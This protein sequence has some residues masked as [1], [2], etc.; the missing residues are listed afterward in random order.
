MILHELMSKILE[1]VKNC[2]TDSDNYLEVLQYVKDIYNC[3]ISSKLDVSEIK[4]IKLIDKDYA[5]IELNEDILIGVLMIEQGNWVITDYYDEINIEDLRTVY[6]RLTS[7]EF[8]DVILE[9]MT[10]YSKHPEC[11]NNLT[12][13]FTQEEITKG[14][15]EFKTREQ[16]PTMFGFI[17]QGLESYKFYQKEL[18][19]G[20]GMIN[21]NSNYI[22]KEEDYGPGV[23]YYDFDSKPMKFKYFECRT[24]QCNSVIDLFDENYH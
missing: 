9:Y 16:K 2:M 11:L 7:I 6:K 12:E 19:P 5:K 22:F 3:I 10:K 18:R 24:S 1:I 21:L 8:R 23:F 14:L 17:T 15:A 13:E 20:T 4:N